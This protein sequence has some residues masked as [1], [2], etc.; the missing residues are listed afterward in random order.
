M[1]AE[2]GNKGTSAQN[3]MHSQPSVFSSLQ[4]FLKKTQ[5]AAF[6]SPTGHLGGMCITQVSHHDSKQWMPTRE[7][8]SELDRIT[9]TTKSD[10]S[11]VCSLVLE[12]YGEGTPGPYAPMRFGD[13]RRFECALQRAQAA[14]AYSKVAQPARTRHRYWIVTK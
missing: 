14:S 7:Q 10:C 1:L 6:T 11:Q 13:I 9:E 2:R 4:G 3:S 12:M 8:I 5:N